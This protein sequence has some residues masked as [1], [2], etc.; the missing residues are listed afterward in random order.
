MIFVLLLDTSETIV[1]AEE[2][3]SSLLSATRCNRAG[4]RE[5]LNTA[6]DKEIVKRL[7]EVESLPEDEKKRIFDYM[8]LIIRDYKTKKNDE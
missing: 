3:V 1:A 8:D 4:A 5:R 6:Y 7:D 2:I